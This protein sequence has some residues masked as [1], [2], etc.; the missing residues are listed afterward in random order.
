M[1]IF[2]VDAENENFFTLS[3][4]DVVAIFS[5]PQLYHT[6]C[7]IFF[8]QFIF[9]MLWNTLTRRICVGNERGS[10]IIYDNNL[11][12][13]PTLGEKRKLIQRSFSYSIFMIFFSNETQSNQIDMAKNDVQ[14]RKY[15]IFH[16]DLRFLLCVSPETF[17]FVFSAYY[18]N[19]S[20]RWYE[21]KQAKGDGK[22]R[23]FLTAVLYVWLRERR[24]RKELLWIIFISFWSFFRRAYGEFSCDINSPSRWGY[25]LYT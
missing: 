9:Q 17:C 15:I 5:H 19:N 4:V 23:L 20:G 16:T 11:I 12:F 24:R 3:L 25:F 1:F 10:L 18:V 21:T 6:C 14:G 2:L 8:I 22:F 7:E 13:I